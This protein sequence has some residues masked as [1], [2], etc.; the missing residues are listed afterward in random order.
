MMN[1]II[2]IEQIIS[3]LSKVKGSEAAVE[4][5]A[6]FRS[7]LLK[8]SQEDDSEEEIT[9][10]GSEPKKVDL[11][12][13]PLLN[14]MACLRLT[15]A[16]IQAAHW[17]SKGK[18]FY[19]DHLLYER[20]YNE[21]AEEID[22]YAEKIIALAGEETVNPIK[23]LDVAVNR[24]PQYVEFEEGMDGERIAENAL[25]AIEYVLNELEKLYDGIKSAG[26]M[27]MGMDDLLMEMHSKQQNHLYLIQ[28]RLKA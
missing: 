20:I 3:D 17:I 2:K 9:E 8:K 24:I 26:K 5:I 23:V 22:E 25:N 1:N 13:E 12:P 14:F 7:F 18:A 28:Q 10:R 16:Y 21:L 11:D 27:T 19:G 6:A 15:I 4:K